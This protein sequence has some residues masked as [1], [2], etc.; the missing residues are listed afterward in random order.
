MAKMLKKHAAAV[1]L[2]V[3]SA[4]RSVWSAVPPPVAPG[5]VPAAGDWI[6]LIQGYIEGG[7]CLAA[8]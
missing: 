7:G 8:P 1:G 4:Y 3:I 5:T 2:L 6:A